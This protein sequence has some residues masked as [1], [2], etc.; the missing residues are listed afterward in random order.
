MHFIDRI[1][2]AAPLPDPAKDVFHTLRFPS[3]G[4]MKCNTSKSPGLHFRFMGVGVNLKAKTCVL[5]L[6]TD[7]A[8][9]F[10][11]LSQATLWQCRSFPRLSACSSSTSSATR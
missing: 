1:L 11:S 10:F 2:A 9:R 6:I 7:D 5:P 8:L 4:K 3:R